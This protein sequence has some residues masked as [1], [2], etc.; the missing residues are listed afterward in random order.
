VDGAIKLVRPGGVGKDAFNPKIDFACCLIFPNGCGEP[1]GNF[2]AAL[3]EVLCQVV[4]HLGAI[5]SGGF[6][7]GFC[8]ARCFHGIA[9]I[10]AIAQRR[11]AQDLAVRSAH[12]NAIA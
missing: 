10:F 3:R 4:Q 8:L 11:L 2:A 7:P 12:F 6:R 9:D 5:M 1:V